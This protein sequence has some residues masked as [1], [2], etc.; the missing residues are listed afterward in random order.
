MNTVAS[1]FKDDTRVVCLS[2]L[3]DKSDGIRASNVS[4]MSDALMEA[5][6]HYDGTILIMS[7]FEGQPINLELAIETQG[8]NCVASLV[9]INTRSISVAP[10][11][12]NMGI[13]VTC[14][15]TPDA[16]G[17]HV[18]ANIWLSSYSRIRDYIITLE[19]DD[20]DWHNPID[21]YIEYCMSE[22]EEDI[23][24]NEADSL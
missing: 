6:N 8:G 18:S 23:T 24:Q 1:E 10:T 4:R 7:K 21:W 2:A 22:L 15:S 13:D 14:Y 17:C 11:C 12:E 5:Y 3:M 9:N 16:D 19:D 20:G